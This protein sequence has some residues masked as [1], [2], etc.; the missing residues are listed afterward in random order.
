MWV[1]QANLFAATLAVLRINRVAVVGVSA[2]GPAALEFARRYPSRSAGHVAHRR[3]LGQR[4]T[5][6]PRS[7][8]VQDGHPL[9][10]RSM[11]P[12]TIDPYPSGW[13]ARTMLASTS[14]LTNN[15]P[16]TTQHIA[17][18]FVPLQLC[19]QGR[20]RTADLTIFS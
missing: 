13:G 6:G 3:L 16:T 9:L 18:R 10:N 4:L 19:G 15:R 20:G 5:P 11:P 12:R 17:N 7:L 14:S 2:G 1:S 8:P